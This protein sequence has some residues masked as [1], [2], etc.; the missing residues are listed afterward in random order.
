MYRWTYTLKQKETRETTI[1]RFIDFCTIIIFFNINYNNSFITQ[2]T[3]ELLYIIFI[4]RYLYNQIKI[5]L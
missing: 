3:K 2:N 1:I 5:E 4:H